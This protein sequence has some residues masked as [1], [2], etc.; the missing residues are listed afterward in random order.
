V[1]L[2]ASTKGG[3][4]DNLVRFGDHLE[5]NDLNFN[6]LKCGVVSLVP[7]GRQKRI[8]VIT[9]PHIRYN[10][11]LLPQIGIQDLWKYLGVQFKGVAAQIGG[12]S[13]LKDVGRLRLAPLKPQQR[14]AIL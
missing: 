2:V 4:E 6:L 7:S 1:I 13:L 12:D 5:S 9:E 14:L 10:D 8:K 11:T 3:L